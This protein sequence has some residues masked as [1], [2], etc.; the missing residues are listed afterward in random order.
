MNVFIFAGIIL[1]IITV[2]API[3][4]SLRKK[5]LFH[6][7]YLHL[8]E[9][10]HYPSDEINLW[11]IKNLKNHIESPRWLKGEAK[12]KMINIWEAKS[13]NYLELCVSQM[14]S[15]ESILM[16]F[17]R[18]IE[19]HNKSLSPNG[20]SQKVLDV[21]SQKFES[22]FMAELD[23]EPNDISS[24]LRKFYKIRRIE[25]IYPSLSPGL[26]ITFEKKQIDYL[27]QI[28]KLVRKNAPSCPEAVE[29]KEFCYRVS[30]EHNSFISEISEIATK[31]IEKRYGKV[32][33]HRIFRMQ[34]D[35]VGNELKSKVHLQELK[36]SMSES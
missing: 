24:L 12:L 15:S 23:K 32:E 9:L 1:V 10:L 2:T 17:Y 26:V 6:E 20:I 13:N 22:L 8:E 21:A 33:A 28:L 29:L 31:V 3:I 4:V 30:G 27:N 7:Q 36:A 25:S 19:S 11:N 5:K 18:F 16:Q 14:K 34:I 35:L